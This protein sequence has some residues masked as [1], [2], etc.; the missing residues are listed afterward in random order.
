M[1]LRPPDLLI[2]FV[3]LLALLFGVILFAGSSP[4]SL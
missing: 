2:V 4:R 1:H 3:I